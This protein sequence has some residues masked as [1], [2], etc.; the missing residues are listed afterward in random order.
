M[1]ANSSLVMWSLYEMFSN[2]LEGLRSF[3]LILVKVHDS[4]VYRN[5]NMRRERISFT[6]V[7]IC[8]NFFIFN[9]AEM[10]CSILERT[11]SFV[12]SSETTA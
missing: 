4:Q 6:Y 8:A 9:R 12:L 5:M 11:S 1:A 2:L 3:V 10:A 7:A